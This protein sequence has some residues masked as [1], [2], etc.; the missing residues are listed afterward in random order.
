MPRANSADDILTLFFLFSQKTSFDISCKLSS[1]G[2]SLHEISKPFSGL[3]MKNISKCGL[4]KFL[5]SMLSFVYCGTT[6]AQRC[7]VGISFYFPCLFNFA[8]LLVPILP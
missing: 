2:D 4:P 1:K 6:K 8:S 5:P 7:F 3:S